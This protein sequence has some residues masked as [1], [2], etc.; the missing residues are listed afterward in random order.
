MIVRNKIHVE[1]MQQEPYGS[2]YPAIDGPPKRTLKNLQV[3]VLV[4][5]EVALDVLPII[6]TELIL[7]CTAN[8]VQD[9]RDLG[10]FSS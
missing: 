8:S 4:L 7:T 10:I 3:Q 2:F 9:A 1:L 5:R 6:C